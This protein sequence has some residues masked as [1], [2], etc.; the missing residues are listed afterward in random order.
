[1]QYVLEV[2]DQGH[3]APRNAASGRFGLSVRR[4]IHWFLSLD[5]SA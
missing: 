2:T 5:H 1:M 4:A 3:E